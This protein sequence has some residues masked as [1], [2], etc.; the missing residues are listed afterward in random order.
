MLQVY[1]QRGWHVSLGATAAARKRLQEWLLL[2]HTRNNEE[3]GQI[4][5]CMYHATPPGTAVEIYNAGIR[6]ESPT[7]I[8]TPSA[9]ASDKTPVVIFRCHPAPRRCSCGRT[10]KYHSPAADYVRADI[11][12][13]V[14]NTAAGDV[15]AFTG[16]YRCN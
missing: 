1:S 10:L 15:A 6:T 16:C 3:G 7:S 13:N 8:S 5:S 11:P 9:T 2:P 12:N 4:C 14:A